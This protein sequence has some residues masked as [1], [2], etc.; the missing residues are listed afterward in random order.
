MTKR[1]VD[2]D[3]ELLREAQ[4]AL[5]TTGLKDTVN[6]ALSAAGADS[7][8]RLDQIRR[9]FAAASAVPLTDADREDAW[10]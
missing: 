10:H 4:I 6:A 2:V 7:T 5:G 3:D 1:L 9:S 8:A